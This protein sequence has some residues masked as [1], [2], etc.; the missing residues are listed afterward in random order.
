[1][2]GWFWQEPTSRQRNPYMDWWLRKW[3]LILYTVGRAASVT[4]EHLSESL[5]DIHPGVLVGGFCWEYSRAPSNAPRKLHCQ[6]CNTSGLF[7]KND[8]GHAQLWPESLVLQMLLSRTDAPRHFLVKTYGKLAV[9]PGW[10]LTQLSTLIYVPFFATLA[11]TGI[12]QQAL[13][14]ASALQIRALSQSTISCVRWIS[15]WCE[16]RTPHDSESIRHGSIW[17]L[18]A[19][20]AMHLTN[21]RKRQGAKIRADGCFR[22]SQWHLHGA[23]LGRSSVAT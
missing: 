11:G 20:V 9:G 10:Y 22:W 6:Q 7:Q 19:T 2:L 1:M 5:L 16:A 13:L 14:A 4:C 8:V 23:N 17:T 12:T 3:R 18:C 21:A 15:N